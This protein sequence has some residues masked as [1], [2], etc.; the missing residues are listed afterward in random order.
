M[1]ARVAFN[2]F[3]KTLCLDLYLLSSLSKCAQNLP[4][5]K[6]NQTRMDWVSFEIILV[7]NVHVFIPMATH[8]LNSPMQPHAISVTGIFVM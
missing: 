1:S 4:E 5:M 3:R 2:R 7:I 6:N 8:Q